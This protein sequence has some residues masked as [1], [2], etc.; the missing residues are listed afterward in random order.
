M[1]KITCEE[2]IAYGGSEMNRTFTSFVLHS[3]MVDVAQDAGA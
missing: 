1:Y 2:F 3:E